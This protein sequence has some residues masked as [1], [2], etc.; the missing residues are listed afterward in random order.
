[1]QRLILNHTYFFI[2]L[3]NFLSVIFQIFFKNKNK[4]SPLYLFCSSATNSIKF[5]NISYFTHFTPG[6]K[7]LLFLLNFTQFREQKPLLHIYYTEP[8]PI[9]LSFLRQISK[10]TVAK[11]FALTVKKSF[12]KKF[13]PFWP[14]SDLKTHIR[15]QSTARALRLRSK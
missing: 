8:I 4:N 13:E 11:K 7:F 1:M 3:K 9:H 2:L 5:A 6:K 10:Q 14:Q 15:L 12:L